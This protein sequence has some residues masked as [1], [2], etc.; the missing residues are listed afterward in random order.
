MTH[1]EFTT[2]YNN[3]HLDFRGQT[4]FQCVDLARCYIKSVLGLRQPAGIE[5]AKDF[6]NNFEKDKLLTSQFIKI[7]NTPLTVPKKGDIVIWSG[8]YGKYG[9]VAIIDSANLM[10][11]IA[12]S[13]NDPG[14]SPCIFKKY[15]YKCVLGFLRAKDTGTI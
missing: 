2:K 4:N 14:Q 5:G 6:Y 12:F 15:S 7:P 11:F 8:L 13:Q 9:H 10:S 1:Q 3:Q